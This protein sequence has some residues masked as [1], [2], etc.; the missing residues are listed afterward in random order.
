[1]S[2]EAEFA[3]VESIKNSRSETLGVDAL[4]LSIV[5]LERQLRRLFTHL[6][7][8]SEAFAPDSIEALLEA[9]DRKG[10]YVT[11]FI[12][13]IDAL[14]NITVAEMVGDAYADL[15]VKL[16]EIYKVRNRV[17]HGQLTG[18]CLGQFELLD[19]VSTVREWCGLLSAGAHARVGYDGFER[20]SLRKSGQ[21]PAFA[22][23][24][25][26]DSIEDFETFIQ[27]HVVGPTDW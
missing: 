23:L 11:G 12:S 1:M 10:I 4:T 20:K 5:K 15:R 14:I 13:G 27:D 21:P 26:L 2:L 8:Q 19:M 6:V 18:K 9:L 24:E 3:V 7:F 17:F 22:F 25:Q 16:R